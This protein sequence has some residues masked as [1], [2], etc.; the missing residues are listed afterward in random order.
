MQFHISQTKYCVVISDTGDLLPSYIDASSIGLKKD[1]II[2]IHS[3]FNVI[4][5]F[6]TRWLSSHTY[7]FIYDY[8]E[9]DWLEWKWKLKRHRLNP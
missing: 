5:R 1:F 6:A 8:R 9:I 4:I 7:T 2:L 3:W